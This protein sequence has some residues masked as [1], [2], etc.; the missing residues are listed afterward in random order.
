MFSYKG[1]RN[2]EGHRTSKK[3]MPVCLAR[4]KWVDGA[5][6]SSTKGER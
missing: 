2:R 1:H 4:A 3:A 5:K 6:T